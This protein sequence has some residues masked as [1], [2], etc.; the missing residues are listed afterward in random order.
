MKGYRE[1]FRSEVL[2]RLPGSA[3]AILAAF[4]VGFWVGLLLR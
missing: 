2:E 3:V 4:C 1:D